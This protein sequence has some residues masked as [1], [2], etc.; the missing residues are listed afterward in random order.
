MSKEPLL[1]FVRYATVGLLTN[2]LLFLSYLALTSFDI[3]PKTAM[4]TLYVPGVLLAFAANRYWTFRHQGAI[5]ASMAR[6]LATYA[7]GYVLNFAALVVLVDRLGLPDDV[8]VLGLIVATAC[9]LFVLQR[10]WVFTA[11]DRP[12]RAR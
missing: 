12:V 9:L 5:P 7:L 4:S 3:G 6:Y 11:V 10:S 2:G 1:Q 8:V